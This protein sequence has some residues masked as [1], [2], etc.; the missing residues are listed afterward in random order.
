MGPER[1]NTHTYQCNVR[2]F[3]PLVEC[4]VCV[5]FT[6]V[7][8]TRLVDMRTSRC[9]SRVE[10][11]EYR[12]NHKRS[13]LSFSG[14]LA[15]GEH[16]PHRRLSFQ[17]RTTSLRVVHCAFALPSS[18]QGSKPRNE[19]PPAKDACSRGLKATVSVND[20]WRDGKVHH[21]ALPGCME[22][23]I[24]RT[25]PAPK[26]LDSLPRERRR[27]PARSCGLNDGR[28]HGAEL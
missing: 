14:G 8:V 10:Y 21:L 6:T 26:S 4:R 19:T 1:E 12:Q 15:L 28:G 25:P 9:L 20:A 23:L 11:S 18:H 22:R 7:S 2:L 24:S 3:N 16:S 5:F 13:F 27:T 17:V